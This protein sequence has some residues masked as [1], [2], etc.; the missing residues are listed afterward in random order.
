MKF[1]DF[2]ALR[3][4]FSIL[5]WDISL[6]VITDIIIGN[7]P[8]KIIQILFISYSAMIAPSFYTS[9]AFYSSVPDFMFWHTLPRKLKSLT[10]TQDLMIK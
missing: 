8:A 1:I 10:Y 3:S 7:Q 9:F 4:N 5:E 6:V 2:S